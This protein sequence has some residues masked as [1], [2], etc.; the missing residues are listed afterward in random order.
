VQAGFY[1]A[2]VERGSYA[3]GA[4]ADT[5]AIVVPLDTAMVR[6]WF[7]RLAADA[8]PNYG[9]ALVPAAGS[10]IVRGVG[11]LTIDSSAYWPTLRVVAVN[12]AGTVRDT[13]SFSG[14]IDSFVGNQD[15]VIQ[16][17]ALLYLQAGVVYRSQVHFPL[18]GIPRG[19]IINAARIELSFN[20]AGSSLG[21][22]VKDRVVSGQLLV[23][24]S[25]I[26][27]SA[28][29]EAS[30]S[31]GRP[32]SESPEIY[33]L[34]ARHFAQSWLRGPNYGALLR[35]TNSAETRTIDRYAFHNERSSDPSLRPRLHVTYSVQKQ[36]GS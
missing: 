6:Q 16:D 7:R 29:S 25:E 26:T 27:S 15:N 8:V 30:G 18:A 34:D 10:T 4:A 5:H 21:R 11:A 28:E 13:S 24:G 35:V 9:V 3:G 17:P 2:G 23:G 33:A 20:G 1:E 22:F 12:A 31:Y 36:G 14:G 19:A 32:K